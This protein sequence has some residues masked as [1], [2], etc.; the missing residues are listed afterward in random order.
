MK[1]NVRGLKH[2]EPLM[3]IRDVVS[4]KCTN[5]ME[6]EVPVDA[7]GYDNY[8]NLVKGFADMPGCETGVKE[9]GDHCIAKIKGGS[10]KCG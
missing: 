7:C 1:I 4:N 5:Y 8:D 2:P 6:V 9:V 10:C 3:K